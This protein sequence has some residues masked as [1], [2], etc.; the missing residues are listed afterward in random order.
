[1]IVKAHENRPNGLLTVYVQQVV[2]QFDQVHERSLVIVNGKQVA[3]ELAKCLV[4]WIWQRD[5]L[6]IHHRGGQALNR[7]D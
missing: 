5:S 2:D 6:R 1:M 4:D 3:N 7:S